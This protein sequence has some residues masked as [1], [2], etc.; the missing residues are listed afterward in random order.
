MGDDGKR[1]PD[2][3]MISK[4]E[5]LRDDFAD[6]VGA[7]KAI[8]FT[9]A[10]VASVAPEKLRNLN[11]NEINTLAVSFI[12]SQSNPKPSSDDGEKPSGAPAASLKKSGSS[13]PASQS[14]DN[15][16]SYDKYMEYKRQLD[17]VKAN[18]RRM[19]PDAAEQYLATRLPDLEEKVKF[20]GGYKTY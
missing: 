7:Q 15:E 2:T 17:E 14:S 9:K 18:A 19:S 4:I 8:A 1:A 3:Q 5:V 16:P 6:R 20:H 12:K 10:F 11:S 13:A